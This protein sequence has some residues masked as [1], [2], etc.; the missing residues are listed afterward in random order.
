VTAEL[1]VVDAT[2][3]TATASAPTVTTTSERRQRAIR[4]FRCAFTKEILLG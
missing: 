3:A 2:A 4:V 1:F